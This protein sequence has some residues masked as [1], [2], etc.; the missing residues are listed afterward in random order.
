MQKLTQFNHT[1][2]STPHTYSHR[3]TDNNKLKRWKIKQQ[4]K[5]KI[6]QFNQTFDYTRTK[7]N[8]QQSNR[9]DGSLNN[10]ISKN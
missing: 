5:P 1:F 9:K 6:T 4:H 8:R 10:N 2:T 7:H 3:K